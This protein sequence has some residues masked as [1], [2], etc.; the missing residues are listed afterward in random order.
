VAPRVLNKAW[1]RVQ[2]EVCVGCPQNWQGQC[3]A[4]QAYHSPEEREHR[5]RGET[6]T[7]CMQGTINRSPAEVAR[8]MVRS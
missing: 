3:R 6:P 4:Y 7:N 1:G 2:D 5:S 8:L